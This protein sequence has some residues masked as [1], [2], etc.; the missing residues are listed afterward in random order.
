VTRLSAPLAAATSRPATSPR[1]RR[2][3][4]CRPG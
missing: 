2:K 3:S 4:R 1:P